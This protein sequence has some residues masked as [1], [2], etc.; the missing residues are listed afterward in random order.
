MAE[1]EVGSKGLISCI[2]MAGSIGNRGLIFC[3]HGR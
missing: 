3:S 1:V 2:A